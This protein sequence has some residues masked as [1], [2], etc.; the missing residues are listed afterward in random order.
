MER[1]FEVSEEK[2]LE[3][4]KYI[5][6]KREKLGYSTNHIEIHTGINK[7]DLSRIENGKKKKINPLYLKE[8]AKI[9]KLNQIEL[10]NLAGFID[11]KYLDSNVDIESIK[12]IKLMEIPLYASVS[13][14][15]GCEK[16]NEPLEYIAIPEMKGNIISVI[17][18]GDSMED[19]IVDGSIVVV[20]TD[21]MPEIG[22][23]GV[24]LTT[25]TEHPDGL[26]KRLRHKNGAYVLE[27]D[28]KKYKDIEI[29]DTN[30]EAF[31][32][33]MKIITNTSKKTKDPLLEKLEK[34]DENQRKLLE[35]LMDNIIK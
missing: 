28:N 9:L 23:I 22:E 18:N 6:E 11:D 15:L 27:S 31:G 34:L 19:T 8:L 3:L 14:G 29:E 4:G 16:I 24:F 10:F 17:V 35:Q 33:V 5:K 2:A 26:V 12:N 21:V 7:A 32:K 1:M 30:I 25:G 13:A 20:D